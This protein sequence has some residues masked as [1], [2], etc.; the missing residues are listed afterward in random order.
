MRARTV[1]MNIVRD[2][3]KPLLPK[4]DTINEAIARDVQLTFRYS[5]RKLE[6]TNQSEE[7]ERDFGSRKTPHCV[8]PLGIVFDNSAYY[9]I[10]RKKTVEKVYRIDRMSQ[11]TM[12]NEKRL[13]ADSF[14]ETDI[15]TI[16]R[17]Y[18]SMF[19][20]KVENVSLVCVNGLLDTIIERFGADT[21]ISHKD[22]HHFGVSVD[23]V[24]SRQFFGWLCGM[25]RGCKVV[26]PQEVVQQ[27][28]RFVGALRKEYLGED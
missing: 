16:P 19:G 12:T 6:R 22:A 4:V 18:F 5:H 23:V 15:N 17:K 10:A 25:G 2:S 3:T 7:R 27:M 14:K 21:I 13:S 8:N 9:L 28:R 1:G 20:G 24:P 11:L 26:A